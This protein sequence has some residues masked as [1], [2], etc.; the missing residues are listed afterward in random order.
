M[1]AAGVLRCWLAVALWAGQ[2]AVKGAVGSEPVRPPNIILVLADD[3]GYGDLG[4]Y[5]HPR[6][7]TPHLDALA[8]EGTRFMQFYVAH[9]VCS[10]SR[11]ALLT[12]QYPSRWS[13]Y[14]HFAW[15]SANAARGMPDWLDPAA[16]MFPRA[17][18][19]A[20]YRTAMFGKWHLGGGSGRMFGGRAI[21]SERAPPVV[22]YGFDETRVVV[23]NGPTWHGAEHR[24]E[25]HELY[26]YADDYFVT[27]SSRMIVDEG[28][29]FMARHV[30]RHPGRP[31]LL[32]LWLHDPHVPL[33]PTA[34]MELPYAEVI[35]AGKRAYYAVVSHM[36]T[37]IGRLLRELDR[38]NLTENTLVIFTSDNG[39][40]A[41]SGSQATGKVGNGVVL[42]TDTA[43]SN[44]LLRGW[45]W[46]LHEGGVR[47][48]LIMRWPGRIPAGR[49]DTDSVL[50]A[51][52]LAPTLVALAGAEMPVGY[53]P[54]GE[55]VRSSWY[56]RDSSRQSQLFWQN[57]T[58]K[59]RG[60]AL[61]MRER[62]WKLLMESDGTNAEL[63]EL[64]IDARES[65]NLARH[66]PQELA[67]LSHKLRRWSEG[68]PAP[69]VRVRVDLTVESPVVET[70]D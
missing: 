53:S 34:E 31:F 46:H 1:S 19:A 14:A 22:E 45:K 61:A 28:V 64:S 25:A 30:R 3:L 13:I 39:A 5:G 48:P 18:Q 63:Y 51:C 49:V 20:G 23:G 9:S 69:L 17:L 32:N 50:S 36:D 58:A 57:P 59:R 16:P 66:H 7:R 43:G 15:L 6:I 55:D 42:A 44:G 67:R 40:A 70:G 24:A 12:G 8:E 54:D 35:D 4:S 60:P 29:D 62:S 38:L 2:G 47:V 26:P 41:R 33:T 52:D 21:N 10:P 27:W 11:A 56:G 37:Q 68:L 65:K